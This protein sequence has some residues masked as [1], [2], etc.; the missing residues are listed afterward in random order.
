[1]TCDPNWTTYLSALLVPTVTAFGAM[2]AWRQWRTA[3][4]KL[5]LD[6]F[7]R[8]LA[9]Y[10]ATAQFLGSVLT[11]G[12]VLDEEL[13]GFISSTREAKWLLD[14]HVAD[15]LRTE[16]YRKALQL[17]S[18]D[19]TLKELPIGDERAANVH[20]QREIKEWMSQQYDVLDAKFARFLKLR[21]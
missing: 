11:T 13:F 1:M 2:I 16:L 10:H 18:L 9:V 17:Q 5:K 20:A 12:K 19:S 3:Q 8:R 14:A 4:N 15:Y 7:E 21:H 6:L